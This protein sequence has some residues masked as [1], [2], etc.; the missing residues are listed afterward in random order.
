MYTGT[1]RS[2]KV[3][4]RQ[5]LPT[6]GWTKGTVYA[7]PPPSPWELHSLKGLS[8]HIDVLYSLQS[9]PKA[10]SKCKAA[11]TAVLKAHP[12]PNPQPN[13][14]PAGTTN[15]TGPEATWKQAEAARGSSRNPQA[16]AARKPLANPL[17]ACFRPACGKACFRRAAMRPLAGQTRCTGATD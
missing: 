17:H 12:E 2:P 7:L 6:E 5:Q 9:H 8:S 13:Y 3:Q 14:T 10:L 4:I 11:C 16:E 15:K 1:N